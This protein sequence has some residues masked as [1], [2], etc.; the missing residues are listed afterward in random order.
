MEPLAWLWC[1]CW[2]CQWAKPQTCH[3]QDVA[4][5]PGGQGTFEEERETTRKRFGNFPEI[6]PK[7]PL[8]Q[9]LATQPGPSKRGQYRL[10]CPQAGRSLLTNKSSVCVAILSVSSW[11]CVVVSAWTHFYMHVFLC[12][13]HMYVCEGRR[14][15]SCPSSGDAHLF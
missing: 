12:V 2:F 3:S 8:E 11:G 10:L 15:T 4:H 9:K 1:S 5:S 13:A 14:S 7:S 6:R